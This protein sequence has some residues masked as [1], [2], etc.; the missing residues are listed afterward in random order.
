MTAFSA[1][2]SYNPL[3]S[4]SLRDDIAAVRATVI[5]LITSLESA[6]LLFT[7]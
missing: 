7:A 4:Q 5:T 2:A 6:G 1:P 3:H